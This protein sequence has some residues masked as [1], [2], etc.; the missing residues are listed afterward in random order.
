L[1]AAGA[2]VAPVAPHDSGSSAGLFVGVRTFPKD[3]SISELPYAVDDAVDLAHAL[4][5]N[6]AARLL[7]PR[8]VALALSG[9]PSKEISKT[10]L[11]EIL[12]AGAS[13]HG[14]SQP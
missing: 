2:G 11:K 10:R 9:S 3:R 4:S 5:M 14:A 7:E 6:P 12:A 8:C 13:R 1:Q